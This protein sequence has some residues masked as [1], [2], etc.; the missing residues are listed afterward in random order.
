MLAVLGRRDVDVLDRSFCGQGPAPHSV[1]IQ[2]CSGAMS[3]HVHDDSL[4]LAYWQGL[5][6]ARGKEKKSTIVCVLC[7][8]PSRRPSR[9]WWAPGSGRGHVCGTP[10]VAGA[11]PRRCDCQM[12]YCV[13]CEHDCAIDGLA[14]SLSLCLCLFGPRVDGTG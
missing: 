12:L 5:A 14:R 4:S 13:Y 3:A 11:A 9:G 2:V 10:V 8:L 6:S 7:E 1:M